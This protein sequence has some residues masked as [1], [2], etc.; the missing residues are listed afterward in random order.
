L[1][2][3]LGTI[4]PS[5]AGPKRPQDRVALGAMSGV[6]KKAKKQILES[7]GASDTDAA[8]AVQA[9]G[10]RQ[11]EATMLMDRAGWN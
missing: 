5:L 2:L 7:A 4:E 1:Q 6:F 3:D 11:A 8:V 9:A 10:K